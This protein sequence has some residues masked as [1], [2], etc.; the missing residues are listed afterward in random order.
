MLTLGSDG[1][2]GQVALEKRYQGQVL[3]FP[4]Y[5]Y[6]LARRRVAG[7]AE[8]DVPYLRGWRIRRDGCCRDVCAHCRVLD[9]PQGH[10]KGPRHA[11]RGVVYSYDPERRIHADN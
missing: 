10:Y 8:S 9:V 11:N 7:E 6:S 4:R 3:L 1:K 2:Q 5:R